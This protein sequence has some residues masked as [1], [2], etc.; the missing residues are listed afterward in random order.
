MTPWIII[1]DL[2]RA[3][4]EETVRAARYAHHRADTYRRP[5]VFVASL[6]QAWMS[7]VPIPRHLHAAPVD[8]TPAARD[9]LYLTVLD[10]GID[11][12]GAAPDTPVLP[13]RI[14]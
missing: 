10:L 12:T 5:G 9:P 8:P 3:N 1:H 14:P 4:E 2:M 11:D 7:R 6:L 13:G